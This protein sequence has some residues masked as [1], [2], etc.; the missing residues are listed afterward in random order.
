M[1][2]IIKLS[3]GLV[4]LFTLTMHAVY[5]KQQTLPDI[6]KNDTHFLPDFSYAGYKFGLE[7]IPYVDGTVV[8]ATE[9]G[10]IAN[11]GKDD[12][13]AIMRAIEHANKV[14][15]SVVVRF[16]AGKFIVSE[17][18]EITRG[19]F[20]LQGA[21]KGQG[22]T[23]FH[24]PRPMNMVDD[25]GKLDELREYLVKYDKRQR[26]KDNNLDVLFSEY[27]WYG[28]FFWVSPKDHRGFSYMSKYDPPLPTSIADGIKGNRGERTIQVNQPDSFKPGQRIQILWHNRQGQNGA[29]VKSL[30]ADTDVK[31]G[32]RHWESPDK[33]LVKQRTQVIS[34]TGNIL[35]I[36]DTLLH[37]IN[38]ALPANFA[39]WQPLENIGL[40]DFSITFPD[41]P[42]FGHHVEAGYNGIFFSGLADSWFRNLSFHNADS[43]I[44][45]YDSA[46]ITISDVSTT[47]MRTAHYAVHMGNVHNVLAKNIQ[48]FNHV[49][50]SLSFNTQST[51]S[52]YLNSEV[53]HLPTLDQHAGANHQNLFDQVTLHFTAH[54]GKKE[55]NKDTTLYPVFWGSGA[56]YWQP[57]HGQFNTTWNL[58]LVVEGGMHTNEVLQVDAVAEGPSARIIGLH[59]NRQ[60]SLNYYPKPYVESL[61]QKVDAVPSLYDYQLSLRKSGNN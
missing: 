11:D 46:N 17:I 41:S 42:F 4:I 36:A 5:A 29:L 58:R 50:H 51:R 56:G 32:S 26:E 33:P 31:I 37:D 43:G 44:L 30:Y 39:T 19:D 23:E 22:G 6:L 47:G 13:Q 20:V 3:A 8:L 2:K 52:V 24:F 34:V 12:S 16:P 9:F 15:G 18:I 45:S 55:S 28:G 38:K 53:F 60:L 40:E 48:V 49:N 59:G 14:E 57:G 10:A 27:S 61:N 54:K 35:T 25:K 1:I 7:D 21:G